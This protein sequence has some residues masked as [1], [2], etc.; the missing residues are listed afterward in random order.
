[1]SAKERAAGLL[2]SLSAAAFVVAACLFCVGAFRAGSM[3]GVAGAVVGL[4]A[5]AFGP[6]GRRSTMAAVTIAAPGA[7]AMPPRRRARRRA[8]SSRTGACCARSR[9]PLH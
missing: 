2:P 3:T 7:A 1:M 6:Y 8:T 5:L 9:A 4:A